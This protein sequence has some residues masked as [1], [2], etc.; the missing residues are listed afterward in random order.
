MTN[1]KNILKGCCAII[2]SPISIIIGLIAS[3]IL[4]LLF[5][6]INIG[7]KFVGKSIK[8]VIKLDIQHII[9]QNKDSIEQ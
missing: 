5:I 8:D 1:I 9:K 3:L 2:L 6:T 4:V 7:C